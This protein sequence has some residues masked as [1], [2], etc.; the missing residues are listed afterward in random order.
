MKV[1]WKRGMDSSIFVTTPFPGFEKS[2]IILRHDG[3]LSDFNSQ[4]IVTVND[5]T[6]DGKIKL[7]NK[8]MKS[9]LSLELQ[10]PFAGWEKV[11]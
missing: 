4:A 1:D 9:D 2:S 10:T 5:K 6:V 11:T 3:E 8:K 7:L